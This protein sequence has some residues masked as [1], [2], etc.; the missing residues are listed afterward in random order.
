MV[1]FRM[2]PHLIS[3]ACFLLVSTVI[4]YPEYVPMGCLDLRNSQNDLQ[5]SARIMELLASSRCFNMMPIG[6]ILRLTPAK[7]FTE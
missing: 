1:D 6:L 4:L 7:C 3:L 5:P 2:R